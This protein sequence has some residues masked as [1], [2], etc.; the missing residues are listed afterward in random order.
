MYKIAYAHSKV[1]INIG[2]HKSIH[3]NIPWRNLNKFPGNLE[4]VRDCYEY[5]LCSIFIWV[6]NISS[7]NRNQ[8]GKTGIAKY[9]CSH[10]KNF[11]LRVFLEEGGSLIKMLIMTLNVRVAQRSMFQSEILQLEKELMMHDHKL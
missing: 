3:R 2:I 8:R 7:I 1:N 10:E 6:M 9:W 5:Y 11:S 4:V